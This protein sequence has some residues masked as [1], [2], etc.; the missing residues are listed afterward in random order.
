MGSINLLIFLLKYSWLTILVRLTILVSGIQCSDFYR[1]CTKQSWGFS[2][3]S[4]VLVRLTILVSGIQCSDFYSLC[5]QQSWGFSGG[6]VVKN[7]TDNAGHQETG[8]PSL[9]P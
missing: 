8:F 1:L 2:D 3:G 6:S 9:G 4:V 7:L 5:T